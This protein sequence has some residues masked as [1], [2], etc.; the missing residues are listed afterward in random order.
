MRIEIARLAPK[1]EAGV[2]LNLKFRILTCFNCILHSKI[3][4]LSLQNRELTVCEKNKSL[5]TWAS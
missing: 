2:S 4:L 3:S 1:L 5:L